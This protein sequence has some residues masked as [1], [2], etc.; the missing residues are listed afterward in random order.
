MSSVALSYPLGG[1]RP[2]S[3]QE[4]KEAAKLA[5]QF[6]FGQRSEWRLE[7]VSNVSEGLRVMLADCGNCWN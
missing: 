2:S 7:T 6:G 5:R 1:Q 4:A 3:T